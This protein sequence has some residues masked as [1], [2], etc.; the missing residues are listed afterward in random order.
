M[1]PLAMTVGRSTSAN[2]QEAAPVRGADPRQRAAELATRT[3]EDHAAGRVLPDAGAEEPREQAPL[4]GLVHHAPA[5]D[6]RRRADDAVLLPDG[7]EPASM[8]A[9][10]HAR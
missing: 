8:R 6:R 9:M 4:D 10:R 3:A 1:K 7:V 2:E 5:R